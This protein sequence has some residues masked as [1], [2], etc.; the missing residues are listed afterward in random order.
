MAIWKDI[1]IICTDNL[2]F[3]KIKYDFFAFCLFAFPSS[4]WLF[5]VYYPP[6]DFHILRFACCFL[7]TN[8]C[9]CLL[10]FAD[11][12][13]ANS[14]RGGQP[15]SADLWT[16]FCLL[17]HSLTPPV[18]HHFCRL[19]TDFVLFFFTFIEQNLVMP[20]AAPWTLFCLLFNSLT[21]P[22][23]GEKKE[24]WTC[25]SWFADFLWWIALSLS[26]WPET[27][28]LVVRHS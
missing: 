14:G 21:P 26:R 16:H 2:A 28:I 12:F 15:R 5:F 22:S 13:F 10:S 9:L 23:S 11:R 19:L 1:E 24:T 7:M 17:F 8:F 27:S 6:F 20:F 4:I 25:I 18:V 3:C